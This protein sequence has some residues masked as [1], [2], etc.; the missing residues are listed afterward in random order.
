MK[1]K[2]LFLQTMLALGVVAFGASSASALVFT[3]TP[4]PSL[5]PVFGTLINFDDQA[6]GTL[7]GASDYVS[8]G[9]AS[10]VETE[11]LG[12]FA[13]YSSSQ[14]L[15]CYIGTGPS[16]ERGLDSDPTGWDGTIQFTF[17]GL[18]DKVGI[19]IADSL[20]AQEQIAIYNSAHTLLDLFVA[21]VGANQYIGFDRGGV[22]DIKYFEIRGDFFAI[23]DLQHT[24]PVP[25]PE[26]YAM[27]GIGLGLMGF[28]ARRRKG[29]AAAA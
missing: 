22:F 14:S 23:D 2:M 11:G 3:G 24:G 13:R 19:G 25:E 15:C 5:S 8:L 21:P 7:V 1:L 20:G 18:A 6:V 17:S 16:G 29:Q 27:M 28:V 10:V 26:I 4:S 12:R 9:V